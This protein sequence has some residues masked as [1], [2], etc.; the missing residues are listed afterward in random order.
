MTAAGWWWS[1][2]QGDRR[3]GTGYWVLGTGAPRVER[4]L[5]FAFVV[6]IKMKSRTKEHASPIRESESQRW[7]QSQVAGGSAFRGSSWLKWTAENHLANSNLQCSQK[8]TEASKNW[9]DDGATA[10]AETRSVMVMFMA[11]FEFAPIDATRTC[12]GPLVIC[13]DCQ[14]RMTNPL[15][16]RN[17]SRFQ[18]S[19]IWV[20]GPKGAHLH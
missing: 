14:H 8:N 20:R 17:P 3:L 18:L 10:M 11:H 4:H 19:S 5:R 1:G 2:C 15:K 6:Q 16:S 12:R 9:E 7:S 13:P